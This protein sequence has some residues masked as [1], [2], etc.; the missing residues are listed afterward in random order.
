MNGRA[1]IYKLN[2]GNKRYIG[3]SVDIKRRMREH[4]YKA[5]NLKI[6]NK[7]YECIRENNGF[8]CE[9]LEECCLH[10]RLEREQKF[11][12]EIKPELNTNNS[13]GKDKTKERERR[14]RFN[15][16]LRYCDCCDKYITA[17]NWGKHKRTNRHIFLS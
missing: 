1:T 17:P 16:K 5:F 15:T 14:Y 8:D 6:Q 3:S 13:F 2:I 10:D 7:L 11:I 9:N 4:K 12:D